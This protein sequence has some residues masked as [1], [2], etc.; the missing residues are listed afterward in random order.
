MT[1]RLPDAEAIIARSGVP[2]MLCTITL[3]D[4]RSLRVADQALSIATRAHEDGP[5]QYLPLLSGVSDFDEEID[6][7]GLEG[8]AVLTQAR[9]SITTTDDLAAMQG[10]WY[11]V[12][13]AKAEIAVIWSGQ[14]WHERLIILSGAVVHSIAFGILGQQT[15]LSLEAGP[16]LTSQSINDDGRDIGT[17]FPA[18]LLDVLGA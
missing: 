15:T 8:S 16:A 1:M 9:V 6:S 3:P 13:A 17:D 11:A 12:T 2:A 7:F 14:L 10:D 18:P 5:Y 4:G